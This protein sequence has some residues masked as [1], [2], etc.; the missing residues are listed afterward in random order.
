MVAA[1][2]EIARGDRVS[3]MAASQAEPVHQGVRYD[4]EVDTTRTEAMDCAR[5]IA[6]RVSGAGG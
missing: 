4:L 2:R 5:S 1:G 6:A 3:G